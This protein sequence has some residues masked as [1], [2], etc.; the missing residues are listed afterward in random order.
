ME[1]EGGGEGGAA[2][3]SKSLETSSVQTSTD[4]RFWEEVNASLK[5]IVG[6]GG[7]VVVSPQSGVVIV[8]ATPANLQ[9]AEKFL[10]TTE[11]VSARQVMLEAKILE[12]HLSDGYQSGV[13][14]A[15]L[16]GSRIA[17]GAA[18]GNF[19]LDNVVSGS[20]G[21]TLG[22]NIPGAM[23]PANGLFSLAFN[24]GN[25]ATVINLIESQGAV[26]VLS[27]PRIAT[28]N[29]QKAVLRVGTDDF[30]VTEVTG[31]TPAA[32]G[33]AATP[34]SVTVQPFFSGIALDVTPQ[35]DDRDNITLHVRPSV[36][37]V[38]E[39]RKVINLGA[40]FGDMTLPLASSSISE[41][42][43][44]VRLRDGQIVAIGG[45]MRQAHDDRKNRLPLLGD[46]PVL[47]Q[48]FGNTSQSNQKRELVVLIK[49]R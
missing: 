5:A 17:Q 49:P 38:V 46:I 13:N 36:S 32:T 23:S 28:T 11:L 1:E 15:K 14:W 2:A 22:G 43:S 33:V 6:E 45:L 19:G 42:D 37:K 25:F 4:S 30:F 29:N 44:V 20:L 9:L 41:T 18:L 8:R 35:I 16:T 27:S 7:S 24:D 12:V 31:G 47:G 21:T 39:N 26:H 34:P 40:L 3:A 48:I 10:R